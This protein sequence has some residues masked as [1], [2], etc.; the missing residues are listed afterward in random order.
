MKEFIAQ[1]DRVLLAAHGLDQFEA[2][3]NLQLD[4]VDEPNTG[5]GGWSSVY[6]L[7][8]GER[9]YYLKRQ[10]NYLTKSVSRPWGEPTFAREFRNIQRYERKGIAAL[11]AAYFASRKVAGKQQAI[12]LTHAL[13]QW[14]DLH[15]YL[16]EWAT[17]P[18][19][20]QQALLEAIGQLAANLHRAGQMHGCFYPKHIFLKPEGTGFRA[21]LIDLEKTRG[22]LWP[23][24][25]RVKDLETLIRRAPQWTDE[26]CQDLLRYYLARFAPE[27]PLAAL[28]GPLN[29]RLRAKKHRV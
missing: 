25:D 27:Q 21:C 16:A 22:L 8:L 7:D 24:R 3:W 1:S 26:Q 23:T 18:E 17:L 12:L 6:R 15:H 20:E 19:T 13:D 2:L 11:S 9:A 29:A 5:R 14:Q 4:A 10:S 28:S